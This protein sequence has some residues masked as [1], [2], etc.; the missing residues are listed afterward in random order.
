MMEESL[1]KSERQRVGKYVLGDKLGEGGFGIVRRAHNEE[2][3]HEYAIKIL[4]KAQV[5]LMQMTPQIKREMTLLTMLKHPNIVQ[6]F[7]ILNS[8][9]KL[10]LVMEFVE[11]G[12]LHSLLTARRRLQ[13][14]EAKQIFTGLIDCLVYCHEQGIY[15]RDLK[16][17]NILISRDGVAKVCDFG[18]T[19]VRALNGNADQLCSTIVGTEDFAAPEIIQQ[20]P[21]NPEKADM[22]SAGIILF[23]II[24]GFCPFRGND[25]QALFANIRACR[26]SFPDKFPHGA[27][28]VVSALLVSNPAKRPSALQ[29]RN[30]HWLSRSTE[31]TESFESPRRVQAAS[32]LINAPS[33]LEL[34]DVDERT[35]SNGSAAGR[36]GSDASNLR[37]LIAQNPALALAADTIQDFHR[38][39]HLMRESNLVKDRRWRL[40]TYPKTFVGSEMVAWMS[41]NL[42]NSKEEALDIGEKMLQADVFHHV[43]R[44]H[45]FKDEYLFYRFTA[46][47]ARNARCSGT[48]HCF[49]SP[50]GLTACLTEN[51]S[52]LSTGRRSGRSGPRGITQG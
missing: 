14:A 15:H 40:K 26:F 12:D 2:N 41:E 24:A 21:Y 20:L 5:Q 47:V 19:S 27:K 9:T 34:E 30:S 3:G 10:Y 23:T 44:D 49:T 38:I 7:E 6:G 28:D 32:G 31:E 48:T 25:T 46:T 29:V 51:P 11:G 42:Q 1:K 8:K 36:V 18:L 39:Y 35:R 4:D 45:C 22:W 37:R 13:E 16:L 50:P 52:N 17:E 33:P 43:C